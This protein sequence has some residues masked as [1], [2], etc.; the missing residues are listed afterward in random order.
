MGKEEGRGFRMENT[1]TPRADSCQCMA[2]PLQQCK[3]I[4]K[5]L[6]KI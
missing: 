6:I 1:C 5:N 4:F 2:E 3:V